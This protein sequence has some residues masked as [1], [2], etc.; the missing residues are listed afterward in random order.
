M[1]TGIGTVPTIWIFFH[2]ISQPRRFNSMLASITVD[3]GFEPRSGSNQK[4]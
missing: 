2:F 3:R 1:P 4:L